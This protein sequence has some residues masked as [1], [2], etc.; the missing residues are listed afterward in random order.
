MTALEITLLVTGVIIFALSFLIPDK[1]ER[2]S[3]K[4]KEKQQEEIRRMM[5]KE[6]D[7]MKL[8]VNEATNETVEYG[9]DKCERSLEKI[10]NDKIMAVN[11]YAAT[12]MEE[13]D[14]N[15]KELMFLYDMLNDKQTDIKNTVRK[16][17][18]TA[19]EVSDATKNI[20][21]EQVYVQPVQPAMQQPV[22]EVYVNPEPVAYHGQIDES[23]F[24]KMERDDIKPEP[25]PAQIETL[26]NRALN[27][28]V[29]VISANEVSVETFEKPQPDFV[30]NISPDDYRDASFNTEGNKNQEILMM[31]NNGVSVVDIARELNLGVGEVK[32]VIDLYK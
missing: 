18:A 1:G 16:A 23:I 2:Q 6:L 17:E 7:G 24:D 28:S 30:P 22:Q 31:Y 12:I 15:H 8:R 10:S 29:D 19:K 3:K 4:D 13:M 26:F 11:E 9:M 20:Q 5:E 14:K 25:K 32:L 21:P 27:D